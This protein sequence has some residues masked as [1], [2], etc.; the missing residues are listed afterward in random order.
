MDGKN[1]KTKD[2][3]WQ[4]LTIPNL[5]KEKAESVFLLKGPLHLQFEQD[6]SMRNSNM[7]SSSSWF[8]FLP[9]IVTYIIY[10]I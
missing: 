8:G 1:T 3:E 7:K 9:S 6:V 4:H 10:Y 5:L 2:L